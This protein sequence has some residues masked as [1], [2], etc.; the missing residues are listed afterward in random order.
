M[1]GI[2]SFPKPL[3][4]THDMPLH[5]MVNQP[6]MYSA[7]LRANIVDRWIRPTSD[8]ISQSSIIYHDFTA[9]VVRFIDNCAIFLNWNEN[10]NCR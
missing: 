9:V 3:I 2:D 10:E 4:T 1:G 8:S 7:V 6:C 5:A